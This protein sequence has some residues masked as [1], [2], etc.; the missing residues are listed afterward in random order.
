MLRVFFF[1]FFLFLKRPKQGTQG[2]KNPQAKTGILMRETSQLDMQVKEMGIMIWRDI[3]GGACEGL[4]M[5]VCLM[6]WLHSIE[7]VLNGQGTPP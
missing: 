3:V 5:L 2:Q 1:W 4:L 7:H 6:R